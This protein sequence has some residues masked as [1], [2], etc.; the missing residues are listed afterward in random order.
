MGIDWESKSPLK[1]LKYFGY[2]HDKGYNSLD[3][4]NK[5]RERAVTLMYRY[6]GDIPEKIKYEIKTF[7]D[8]ELLRIEREKARIRLERE[9]ERIKRLTIQNNIQN[10]TYGE[11]SFALALHEYL[12]S[13]D[14]IDDYEELKT[15]IDELTIQLNAVK[16]KFDKI[17][18]EIKDLEGRIDVVDNDAVILKIEERLNQ[19]YSISDSYETQIEDLEEQIDDLRTEYDDLSVNGVLYELNYGFYGDSRTFETDY[20]DFAVVAG[21]SINDAYREYIEALIDD[22]GYSSISQHQLEECLDENSIYEVLYE[23]QYEMYNEDYDYNRV[24]FLEDHIREF[25]DVD[26]IQEYLDVY[27]FDDVDIYDYVSES[28]IEDVI[29]KMADAYANYHKSDINELTAMGFE[30]TNYIDRNCLVESFL[31]Y[32]DYGEMSSYDGSYETV[33][34]DNNEFYIFRIN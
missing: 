31:A 5:A 6:R 30:L 2:D 8:K 17:N 32:G 3:Q 10:N 12:V 34:F 26:K 29:K 22:L 28:E 27:Q 20:G 21:D 11:D 7:S 23:S 33:Y 18:N 24:S 25:D 13:N 9:R 16:P 15:K 19:L 4:R 14:H 1:I